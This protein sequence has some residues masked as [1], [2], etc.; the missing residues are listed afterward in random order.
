[1][2]HET[3]GQYL[4]GQKPVR[5]DNG[6]CSLLESIWWSYTESDPINSDAIKGG[7]QAIRQELNQHPKENMDAFFTLVS[8]LCVEYE[9]RAFA[10]GIRVGMRL[11][12]ELL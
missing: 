12:A 11:A 4:V 10:E 8:D 7:Y 3:M 9:K 2:N 1:M 6:M 5:Q